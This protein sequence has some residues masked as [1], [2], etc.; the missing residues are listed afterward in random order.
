MKYDFNNS[1]DATSAKLYLNKLIEEGAKVELKKIR[2][3]RTLKQNS[4][5][6]VVITIFAMELGYTIEEAKT[7]LKRMY[8]NSEPSMVYQKKGYKFLRS[9]TTM[10]TKELTNFIEWIRN[11]AAID[12]GI[13]IPTSEEYLINQYNIDKQIEQNKQYL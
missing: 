12:A 13:Y 10:D 6:H 8:S 4:Y 1:I 9:T 5:F 3:K 2:G 11:Y 7:M